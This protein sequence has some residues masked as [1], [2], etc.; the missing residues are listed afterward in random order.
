[1]FAPTVSANCGVPTTVT[2]SLN[3]TVAA[4]SS[5]AMKMAGPPCGAPERVTPVTVGGM[6]SEA[7]PSTR[8]SP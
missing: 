1:M 8:A 5:P 6:A 4:I 2:G 7:L 3:S